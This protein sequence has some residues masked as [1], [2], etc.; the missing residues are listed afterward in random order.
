MVFVPAKPIKVSD[1]DAISDSEMAS[2]IGTGG[3]VKLGRVVSSKEPVKV[4]DI[5]A[6]VSGRDSVITQRIA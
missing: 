5:S 4:P 2:T 6:E 3:R 1:R